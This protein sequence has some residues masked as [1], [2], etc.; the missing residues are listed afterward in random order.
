M[1]RFADQSS[2]KSTRGAKN[3]VYIEKSQ[4]SALQSRNDSLLTFPLSRSLLRSAGFLLERADN[5]LSPANGGFADV[6][7]TF[8][9]SIV[10]V[11]QAADLTVQAPVIASTLVAKGEADTSSSHPSSFY[12]SPQKDLNHNTKR[13]LVKRSGSL[14]PGVPSTRKRRSVHGLAG[15]EADALATLDHTVQTLSERYDNALPKAVDLAQKQDD[16]QDQVSLLTTRAEQL[17]MKIDVDANGKVSSADS[18]PSK[19]P[20]S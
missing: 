5:D 18:L 17:R 14:L 1:M 13:H 2:K 3:S 19:Q 12:K 11:N 20:I 7:E 15:H 8:R 4:Y 10:Q 16:L 9:Q 6:L